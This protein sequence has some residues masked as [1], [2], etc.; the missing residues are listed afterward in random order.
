MP[1]TLAEFITPLKRASLQN[2]ILG[3]LYYVTAYEDSDVLST[4]AIRAL[5]VRVRDPKK[6][7]NIAVSLSQL[8]PKVELVGQEGGKNLWRLTESGKKQVRELLSLPEETVEAQNEVSALT[9][10]ASKI[11]DTVVRDYL[12]EGIDCLRFNALRA[13]IVFLWS[14]AMRIAQEEVLKKPL[15]DINAS[16]KSHR[17]NVREIKTLGDFSYIKDSEVVQ[18]ARDLGIYDKSEQQVLRQCLD[19]RNTCGHPSKYVPKIS[20]VKSFVEDLIGIVF[21]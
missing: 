2:R 5:L 12:M 11:S 1:I 15:A 7:S 8:V 20:K 3:V 10:I 18:T 17:Q 19:L 4:E 9:K 13:A 21:T 14:G 16:L 6:D